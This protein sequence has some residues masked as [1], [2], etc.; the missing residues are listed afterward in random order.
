MF[1]EECKWISN[2][3][4]KKWDYMKLKSCCKTKNGLKIEEAI[5]GMGENLC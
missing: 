4:D 5:H 1:T 2:R 3:K